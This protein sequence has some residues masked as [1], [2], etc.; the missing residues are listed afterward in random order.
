M[1]NKQYKKVK[2]VNIWATHY[3]FL[4]GSHWADQRDSHNE[5]IMT[6]LW[7]Q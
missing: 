4:Q 5:V 1:K 6:S 3:D 7:G 2:E